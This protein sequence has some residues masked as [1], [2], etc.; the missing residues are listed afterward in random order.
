LPLVQVNNFEVARKLTMDARSH[1]ST[2]SAASSSQIEST[3]KSSKLFVGG[4]GNA[5]HA[6][7][8]IFEALD[9]DFAD[10]KILERLQK[11]HNILD[12]G[13]TMGLAIGYIHANH[14]EPYGC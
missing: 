13:A 9:I 5:R 11:N 12:F 3:T 14:H 1:W 6:L 7:A 10:L 8:I 2:S 4:L